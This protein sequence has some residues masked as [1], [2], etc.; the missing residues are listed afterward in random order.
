MPTEEEP[1]AL[2]PK[3][4]EVLAA[5]EAKLDKLEQ[6]QSQVLAF[7]QNLDFQY[8]VILSRLKPV[9][10]VV[11]PPEELPTLVPVVE[12]MKK[13]PVQ[14]EPP[15]FTE[16]GQKFSK[17]DVS[18][19]VFYPNGKPVPLVRVEILTENKERFYETRNDSTGRWTAK[20][21]PGKY[22][23]S[24]E[25]KAINDKPKVSTLFPLEIDGTKKVLELPSYNS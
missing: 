8:K 10:V 9:P 6:G 2:S 17:T 7:L 15:S 12:P 21:P 23:I 4:S 14:E 16:V 20:L 25:K 11:A 3:A 1:K 13:A 24:L 18:Q 5:L 22:L 19:K